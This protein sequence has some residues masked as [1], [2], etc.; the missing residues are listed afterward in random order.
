MEVLSVAVL[1]LMAGAAL[2][3]R[4]PATA[5]DQ[6]EQCLAERRQVEQQ[7]QDELHRSMHAWYGRQYCPICRPDA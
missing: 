6:C 2:L 1:G 5:C 4:I 3:W 7:R